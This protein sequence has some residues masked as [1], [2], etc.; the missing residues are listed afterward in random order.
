MILSGTATGHLQHALVMQKDW[1]P[2]QVGTDQK[3]LM[4]TNNCQLVRRMRRKWYRKLAEKCNM[5]DRHSGVG[6]E[7]PPVYV[8]VP[9]EEEAAAKQRAVPTSTMMSPRF[10]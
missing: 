3:A 6:V 8:E 4:M 5:H 10:P 1:H 9:A 2:C 7:V